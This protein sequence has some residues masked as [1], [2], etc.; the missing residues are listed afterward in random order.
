MVF[1]LHIYQICFHPMN[2][3]E[4]SGRLVV[5]F[6]LYSYLEEPLVM[7]I[8]IIIFIIIVPCL[9][10]SFPEDLRAAQNVDIYHLY[11]FYIVCI[12]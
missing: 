6:L 11:C 3:P 1:V 9:R 5:D 2:P 4:P 8:F 7:H 10:S 12:L